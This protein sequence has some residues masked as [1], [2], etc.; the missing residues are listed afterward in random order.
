MTLM[1][2]KAT[3]GQVVADILAAYPVSD[4]SK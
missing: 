2:Q 3:K 4:A 1:P